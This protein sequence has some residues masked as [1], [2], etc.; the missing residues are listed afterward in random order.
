MINSWLTHWATHRPDHPAII[1]EDQT[2]TYSDLVGR[3]RSTTDWLIDH[4]VT[5]GDRVAWLGSNRPEFI[6]LFFA[7]ARLGAIFVPLNSRLAVPEH[8]AQLV[9]C[10]ATFGVA[11]VTFI[12]HLNAAAPAELTVKAVETIAQPGLAPQ[13]PAPH[14]AAHE[15]PPPPTGAAEVLIVYTSGTTGAPKGAV[16]TQESTF[17]TVLNGVAAQDLHAGDVALSYLPLFHVGGL[18]NQT[19]PLLYVGGTVI[20]HTGFDPEATL[21]D[22]ANHQVTVTLFV[23]ATLTAMLALPTFETADLS[24]IRGVMTGSSIVPSD[25]LQRFVDAGLSPGQ[26]YGSTET[27][28]TSIVLRFED[29]AQ[30]GS[31]GKPALHCEARIVNQELQVRGPHLF[32][33]YWGNPEA[34]ARAFDDGWYRTGDLAH[35]DSDGW[36]WI[37]GRLDDAIISGGEN[38]DPIEIEVAL[39]D[40]AGVGEISVVAGPSEKWGQVPV[41][42]VVAD[43]QPPTIGALREHGAGRLAR[44]KLPVEVHH[45][46][47]LPRTALGKVQKFEL[48][49]RLP[50]S[51][52][53]PQAHDERGA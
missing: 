51:I 13:S 31:A 16:H 47:A 14:N 49:R 12:D 4:E 19:L 24:S 9:D 48:R 36:Y 7:C 44:Y 50:T 41:A 25:L 37:D 53:T 33:R 42:F 38:I 23:P 20:L 1:F 27:G 21:R 18:N 17:Y 46:D 43:G 30:V 5:A 22:I 15:L 29:A 8:A 2:I 28:P 52:G 39:A 11:D 3:I 26:I 10:E 32:A 34:T 40:A 45:V 35:I 6:D